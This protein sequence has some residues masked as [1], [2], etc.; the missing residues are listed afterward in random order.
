MQL[1]AFKNQ[2]LGQ[3]KPINEP[4]PPPPPTTDHPASTPE[5]SSSPQE[6][7]SRDAGPIPFGRSTSQ[8]QPGPG[9][10]PSRPPSQGPGSEGLG[11][12]KKWSEFVKPPQAGYGKGAPQPQPPSGGGGIRR[13]F[14][15][16]PQLNLSSA[17]KEASLS[18]PPIL[19]V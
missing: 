2:R 12:P 14:P 7:T 1:E 3:K 19:L 10:P 16:P 17:G 15:L 4:Q 9:E 6:T 18:A 11:L 13:V 8:S 5:S